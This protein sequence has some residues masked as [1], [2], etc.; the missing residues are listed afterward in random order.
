MSITM[1]P[2]G[3]YRAETRFQ[4]LGTYATREAAEVALEMERRRVEFIRAQV[5]AADTL[6]YHGAMRAIVDAE[7]AWARR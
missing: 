7:Q 2:G 4:S 3:R 5:A 6:T 1:T